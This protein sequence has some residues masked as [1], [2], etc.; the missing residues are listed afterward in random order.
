MDDLNGMDLYGACWKEIGEATQ[1][2]QLSEF[3]YIFT[4]ISRKQIV[5]FNIAEIATNYRLKQ[6]SDSSHRLKWR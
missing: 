5:G 1:T 3:F 4:L 2:V 6:R